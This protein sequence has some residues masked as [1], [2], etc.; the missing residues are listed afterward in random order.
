MGLE[1]IMKKRLAELGTA[2]DPEVPLVAGE[3]NI[4]GILPINLN[5]KP[6][7]PIISMFKRRPEISDNFFEIS[8]KRCPGYRKVFERELKEKYNIDTEGKTFVLF[9]DNPNVLKILA[10]QGVIPVLVEKSKLTIGGDN[11]DTKKERT[12]KKVELEI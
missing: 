11:Y 7:I 9:D 4:N 2:L 6:R 12:A 10:Q 8:T 1:E 5:I 3:T